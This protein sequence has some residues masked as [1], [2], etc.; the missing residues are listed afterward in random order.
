MEKSADHLDPA[1]AKHCEAIVGPG[2]VEPVRP[3]GR[4][5][6]PQDREAHGRQ[7]EIGHQVDIAAPVPVA[8]FRRLIPIR[9]LEPDDGAFGA[10]P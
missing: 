7:A 9:I 6:F 8:G 4:D 1:L 5:R 3:L 2:E 10:S